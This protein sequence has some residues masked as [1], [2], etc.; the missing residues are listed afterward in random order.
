[1]AYKEIKCL[2]KLIR[3]S[4]PNQTKMKN[5]CIECRRKIRKSTLFN[6]FQRLVLVLQGYVEVDNK[7]ELP[8]AGGLG[9]VFW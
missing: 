1:M 3:N 4:D 7:H 2:F 8:G 6:V 9:P 5:C